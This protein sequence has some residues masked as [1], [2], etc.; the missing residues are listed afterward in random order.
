MSSTQIPKLDRL[1][2]VHSFW[3]PDV[4]QWLEDRDV[5]W[6]WKT[7]ELAWPRR[8]EFLILGEHDALAFRL[9]F[10]NN[11]TWPHEPK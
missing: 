11:G 3:W 9:I 8:T 6:T 7:K 2:S 5:K 4:L 10:E 1:V